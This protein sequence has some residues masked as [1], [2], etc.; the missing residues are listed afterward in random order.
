MCITQRTR[1]SHL[2]QEDRAV[3]QALHVRGESL[4]TIA[5]SIAKHHSTVSREL[6]RNKGSSGA[7]T[8]HLAH[9]KYLHRR[10]TAKEGMR[11]IEND[12]LLE[13]WIEEKLR[14]AHRSGDW[15]PAIIAHF[16]G[17]VCHQTIYTWIWRSRPTLRQLLPRCGKYRRRYG[18][19]TAPSKHWNT[20]IRTIATR[21]KHIET[22]TE[23]GH[24]EGDTVLLNRATALLTVVERKSRYLIAE[25]ISAR[26]GMAYEVHMALVARFLVLPPRLRKTL[27]PDRGGE[28]AYWDMT[29]SDVHNLT[30]YF[31]NPH[32]PW[33]RG[34]NEH[35]NGLLR[36]YFPKREK[37]HSITKA[38]V[39]DVVWMIN[40]RP[41][42]LLNW[43]T[44]CEVFGACCTSS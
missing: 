13:R 18:T 15:S 8:A 38:Q 29:E 37:H 14:G 12:P 21:P 40:H 43:K 24:Y 35:M 39:A 44:P 7:Y 26:V 17:R 2:S 4:R 22:R 27:T 23:L 11:K 6:R 34:T 16:S 36:R 30:I 31:A 1:S 10:T 25:L 33:E 41:R 3:I 5:Q 32:S 28:F 9:Q 19:S 20:R 42:K